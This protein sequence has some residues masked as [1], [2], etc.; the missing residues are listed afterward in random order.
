MRHGVVVSRGTALVLV[1]WLMAALSLL[2]L[3]SANSVRQQTQRISI[4]LERMRVESVLDVGI[5]LGVQKLMAEPNGERGYRRLRMQLGENSLQL[6]VIPS[7]GLVDVNVASDELLQAFFERVG[8]LSPG[9][10]TIMVAR[11]RD[12]LDPDDEPGG[13]GGAEAP[14]YRAA[15]RA[16]GPRNGA[17]DDLS[18]LRMVLGMTSE[19]Y[20]IIQPF[21]GVNGQARIRID[22]APPP[23]IDMLTGQQGLGERIHSSPPESRESEL[24]SNPAAEFFAAGTGRAG[25]IR[26]RASVQTHGGRWWQREAWV[27]LNARPDTLAPWTTLSLEPTRRISGP[28]NRNSTHGR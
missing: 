1:L 2:V 16:S 23:L 14:Q 12:Y 28:D 26:V 20:D 15:G 5:Q 18:E 3:V 19:L 7:S 17:L 25:V 11:V 8:G 13:V 4:D 9:E 21:L 24:L 6:E 10:A 22:A 27:D